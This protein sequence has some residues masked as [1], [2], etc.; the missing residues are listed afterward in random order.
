M[1][2]A[3]PVAACEATAV[4]GFVETRSALAIRLAD[5]LQIA[6]P[7]ISLMVLL[8]VAAGFSLAAAVGSPGTELEFAL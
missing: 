7:R 8:T 6:K 4:A 3:S 5:Y 2:P 1:R